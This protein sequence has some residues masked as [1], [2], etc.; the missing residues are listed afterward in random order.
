[1]LPYLPRH[2]VFRACFNQSSVT[3]WP[4]LVHKHTLHASTYN[5][6]QLCSNREYRPNAI[7]SW[8]AVLTSEKHQQ[9]SN[10]YNIPKIVYRQSGNPIFLYPFSYFLPQFSTNGPITTITVWQCHK[11]LAA[12]KVISPFEKL[13]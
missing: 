11:C 7:I 10:Y 4:F 9:P 5:F 8:D 12:L 6:L 2:N 3:L 13:L 1:M